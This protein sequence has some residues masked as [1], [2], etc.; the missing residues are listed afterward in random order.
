M[1]LVC[2]RKYAVCDARGSRLGRVPG[3]KSVPGGR[4]E[5]VGV[6]VIVKLALDHP[7]Y[8]FGSD[9]EEGYGAVVGWIC[10]IT[11]LMDRIDEGRALNTGYSKDF[12]VY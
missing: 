12:L 2:R 10:R 1:T 4:Q 7:L 8:Y 5:L 6:E 3:S 11:G 9:M